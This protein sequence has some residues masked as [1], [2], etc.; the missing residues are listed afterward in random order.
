MRVWCLMASI[1]A[2]QAGGEGSNP[3]TRSILNSIRAIL[4]KRDY[5]ITMTALIFYTSLKLY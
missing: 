2:F 4:V 1:P 3:F 5:I